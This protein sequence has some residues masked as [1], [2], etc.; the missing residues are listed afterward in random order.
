MT[1]GLLSVH[2]QIKHSVAKRGSGQEG[3]GD[4]RGNK[5]RKNRMAFLYK[6]GPIPFPVEGYSGQAEKQKAMRM[7]FYHRHVWATALIL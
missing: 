5:P 7:H 3:D 2:R 1:R 4:R 6:A